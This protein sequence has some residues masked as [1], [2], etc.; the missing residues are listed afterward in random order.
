MFASS[1]ENFRFKTLSQR[2]ALLVFCDEMRRKSGFV[3]PAIG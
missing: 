3:C 2:A 1:G